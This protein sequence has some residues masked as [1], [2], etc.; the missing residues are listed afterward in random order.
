MRHYRA[1]LWKGKSIAA[2][3]RILGG[4]SFERRTTMLV[5]LLATAVLHPGGPPVLYAG[6]RANVLSQTFCLAKY[7][8][9]TGVNC[10]VAVRTQ[11]DEIALGIIA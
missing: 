9:P 4:F 1:E 3:R 11:G 7:A 10:F 2:P 5:T 6:L 8:L